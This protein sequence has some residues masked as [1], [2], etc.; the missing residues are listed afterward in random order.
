MCGIVGYTGEKGAQPQLLKALR[1][2]EYR[3]YDSSGIAILGDSINIY[4]AKGRVEELEKATPQ[5]PGLMGI[6]HTR[7]ATHGEPSVVNAHP[8]TDCTGK[9]AVVHNGVITNY[10][11]LKDELIHEG[12]RFL[13]ETDTEVI[14]H[15]IEKYF[16]GNLEEAVAETLVRLQGS[17]AIA[18]IA[19]DNPKM[20]VA[21]NG[22]P[23][24]IGLGI[25]ENMIASDVPPLLDC[26]NRVIYMDDGEVG[27]ITKDTVRINRGG[28]EVAKKASIIDLHIEDTQKGE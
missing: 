2:L 18:V 19:Q 15:L 8:H 13:S 9:F 5:F 11:A 27:I 4:K 7:W 3:G 26:T 10:Q 1:E 25:S 22:S 12:H 28:Q 6:G 16:E 24:V 21:K 17:Y 23:L 14:P 20:V